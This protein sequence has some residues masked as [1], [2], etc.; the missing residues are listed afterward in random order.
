MKK[1][2]LPYN[3][4]NDYFDMLSTL[5]KK[6]FD[7]IK[8]IYLPAFKEGNVK[9]SREYQE[10]LN[11]P[12]Y[13]NFDNYIKVLKKIKSFNI[14]IALLM[15]RGATLDIIDKY[16]NEYNIK[17]FII[18]DDN[19]AKEIRK[20]YDNK[21]YLILSITRVLSYNDIMTKDFSMYDEIVLFFWFNKHLDYIKK[22]P[23]KYNYSI[24]VNS[25]CIYNCK[26]AQ[27]H[28]FLNKYICGKEDYIPIMISS[29]DLIL[30]DKY[31]NSYKLVDRTSASDYIISSL[32]EYV[33]EY[34]KM[35]YNT[36]DATREKNYNVID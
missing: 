22:L 3:F 27:S 26:Y 4:Q 36:Y 11:N 15:Q 18:G 29:Y 35:D 7:Y 28:W 30:F 10:L 24:L 21:I 16:Y 12:S 6:Y 25:N 2:E 19:L 1:F 32:K 14:D 33:D 20:K 8:F 9:N 5:D 17:Y 34:C 31:I 23:S 13:Y